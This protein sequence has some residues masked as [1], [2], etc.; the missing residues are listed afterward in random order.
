MNPVCVEPRLPASAEERL[1]GALPLSPLWVGLGLGGLLFLLYLASGFAFDV[2]RALAVAGTPL[3]RVPEVREILLL[4]VLLGYALATE[5]LTRRNVTQLLDT[6]QS[7]LPEADE[8]D[9]RVLGELL[10]LRRGPRWIAA[11]LGALLGLW[12]GIAADPEF[13]GLARP[14][15]LHEIWEITLNVGVC[16][17]FARGVY[18][19]LYIGRRC[20]RVA[21]EVVDVDLLDLEPLK[22]FTRFGMRS[23]TLWVVGGSLV[24][25]FFLNWGFSLFTTFGVVATLS[26][27]SAALLLPVGGVHDRI[28]T[29]KRLAIVRVNR[30][31]R[32]DRARVLE[33]STG[34]EVEAAARLPGLLAYREHL[35]SVPEWP[36]DLPTLLRSAL[37]LAIAVGSWLGGAVVERLLGAALD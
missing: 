25:L 30:V 29:E 36:F 8:E 9:G 2:F 22:A 35:D 20:A 34:G 19:S 26:M 32:R 23:A 31:L 11:G 4:C 24:A 10:D 12:V 3:W 1:L 28:R 7:S 17:V 6:L 13:I 18:A 14:G 16:V 37:L 27:A 15:A 33:S 5:P 21:R